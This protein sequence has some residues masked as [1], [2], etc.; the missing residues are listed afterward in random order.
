MDEQRESAAGRAIHAAEISSEDEDGEFHPGT[1]SAANRVSEKSYKGA[2]VRPSGFVIPGPQERHAPCPQFKLP[3]QLGR[4]GDGLKSSLL[5]GLL[6]CPLLPW[7]A[8]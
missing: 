3:A 4:G 2:D 7:R 8:E 6:S 1:D 5:P